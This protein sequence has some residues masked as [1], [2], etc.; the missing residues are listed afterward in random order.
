MN[1]ILKKIKDLLVEAK[2]IYYATND[3]FWLAIEI[4]AKCFEE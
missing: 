1:R 3:M 4:L 2:M